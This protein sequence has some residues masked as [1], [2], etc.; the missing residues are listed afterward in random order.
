[1][2][3]PTRDRSRTWRSWGVGGSAKGQELPI[4]LKNVGGGRPE[5]NLGSS[6]SMGLEGVRSEGSA[7]IKCGAHSSAS[8][9]P[10][11]SKAKA[12]VKR[13]GDVKGG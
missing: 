13:W 11:F 1:M 4:W 6:R 10:F 2:W 5:R 8:P 3:Q 7:V 12:E 9:K